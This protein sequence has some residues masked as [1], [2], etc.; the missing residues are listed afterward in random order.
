MSGAEEVCV[1]P[2]QETQCQPPACS[3]GH[4]KGR[5]AKTKKS[6]SS[7]S[8][9][10]GLLFP[11]SRI[12]RQLRRGLFARHFSARAPVYLAAVLQWVTHKI[13]DAAAVVCK[14]SKQKRISP[15]HMEAALQRCS[16][17]QQL[18]RGTVRPRG[19][20]RAVRQGKREAS[21]SRKKTTKR[22]SKKRCPGRRAAQKFH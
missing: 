13:V 20:G 22:K 1:G 21:P 11:V 9:Q 15:S 2:E 5:E 14:K 17:L 18:L 7:R 3:A 8:S 12:D 16:G 4:S 6:R 10:A 19:R